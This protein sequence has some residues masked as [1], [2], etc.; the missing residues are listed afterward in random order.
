MTDSPIAA[1]TPS[2]PLERPPSAMPTE[3]LDALTDEIVEGAEDASTIRK[4]RPTST[5]SA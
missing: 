2:L 1:T 3:E 5:S 4:F